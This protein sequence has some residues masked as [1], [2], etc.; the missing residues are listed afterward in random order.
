MSAKRLYTISSDRPFLET[1]AGELWR[2]TGGDGFELSRYLVLLPTRRACRMLGTAF[3]GI[4]NGKPVLLP[5]MR[6]L[7]DIDEDELS[8]ADEESLDLPPAIPLQRRLMLLTQQVKCRDPSMSW[9]QAALAADALAKFLDQIQISSCDLALLPQIV[10]EQ[11]LAE[12]W[13]QTL[14]F[15]EIVTKNWPSILKEL[16]C[17]DP[18]VRRN[19]VTAAQAE[20]WRATP[21]S[22]PIIAA[23]STGSVPA[24]AALLDAIASLPH[25]A[26]V[27]PGLDRDCDNETWADIDE[28]HPQ[29]SMKMLLELMEIE[30]KSVA[31]FSE[32]STP[33]SRVRLLNEALRPASSA[34]AW[35]DLREKIDPTSAAGLTRLTLNH[36]QEEAQV[37]ALRLREA[38]EHDGKTATFVTA[39]RALAERVTVI[40][41]RWNIRIDDSGG[42]PL[43]AK[44]VGAFLNLVLAAAAPACGAVDLLALL[45]HPFAA[46]G[47]LPALCRAKAREAEIRVRRLEDETFQTIR[48]LL[49]P[50]TENWRRPLPLA[51]RISLHIACAEAV[52]ASDAESGAARLWRNDGEVAAAWLDEWREGAE[53]F[54]AVLGADYMA[55]FASLASAKIVRQGGAAHPRLSI[56]GPLEARLCAADLIVL[57]G[58]NEG[59][60][61]PDAGFDPWMSRPM[62]RKF[63]LPSPEYRIGQSAHDFVQLACAEEVL[64]TRSLRANGTPTVPS[65]FLLQIDAVLRAAGLSDEKNDALAP[66]VPWREWAHALDAPEKITPCMRPCP[67]PP[68]SLRPTALSV[69]EITTW[70]RN[71][72]AIYAKHVLKLRKL[73]EIDARLDASDKGT[74]IHEALEAYARAFPDDLPPNAADRLREIGRKIFEREAKKPGGGP[75]IRAFWESGFAAMA[76]WV[77]GQDT[78]RRANGVRV[79][80]AETKGKRLVDGFTL[81]G[82]AD[83]IEKLED[84]GLVI[85]DYKTGGVPKKEDVRSGIEPQ[86]QLLAWIAAAEGFENIAAND[87]CSCEY[88]ALKG[89][90]GECKID[91]FSD[92]KALAA[93]AETGLRNLIAAFLDP[94]TG[95]EAVPRPRLQPH[96]DDYAHLSRQ[97]EWNRNGGAS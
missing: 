10:H 17:Q 37:I 48:D 78:A 27:L 35:K 22:F 87:V 29:H 39:D 53:G 93:L 72:Y 13:Q 57:G 52:A 73:D 9:D 18:V 2:R 31:D 34:E 65:R 97:A 26:V 84:G 96:Y 11:E 62:R 23:G 81:T 55:L 61:P 47:L 28:T 95:Y 44:P 70:L 66:E 92:I 41:Q 5:R 60:W 88:W 75:R 8:F 51:E 59:S 33:S 12:H 71:P 36:P 80:G 63:G 68:V 82:H 67:K 46:C 50:L 20:I 38:L 45:K 42:S 19:A 32:K 90:S 21:P 15:L 25:G 76:D 64:L 79:L 40:L 94:E 83:R 7:G 43:T 30:R 69:T 86:L 74:M 89:G 54:P 6:P 1:L 85:V 91:A 58:L 77:A 24:T 14:I 4:A 16:G 49:A 56:L 3:A